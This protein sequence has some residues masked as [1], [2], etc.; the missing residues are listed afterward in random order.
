MSPRIGTRTVTRNLVGVGVGVA[1]V[2]A[3]GCTDAGAG[4]AMPMRADS[5][6]CD[7]NFI[8]NG[9]CSRRPMP[10]LYPGLCIKRNPDGSCVREQPRG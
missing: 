1:A 8:D 4:A 2:V 10:W 7:G 6:L 3:M 5:S 9:S